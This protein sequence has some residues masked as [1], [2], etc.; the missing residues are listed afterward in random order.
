MQDEEQQGQR[1]RAGL[2]QSLGPGLVTGAADDDPSGI[3]TYTQAGAQFGTG[4]LWTTVLTLPLMASIQLVSAR[5][6]WVTGRGLAANLRER[7]P[8]PLVAA[9]VML[10]V[11]ANTINLGADLSAM[12]SAAHLLAG[13]STHLWLIGFALVSLGLQV[14]LPLSRYSPVL[15]GLTLS[16]L[17]Y[18]A[19]LFAGGI[20][21]GRVFADSLVPHLSAGRDY[22]M[23]IVA[24]LGTTI[25]PYL[26]F[27]QASQEAEGHALRGEA[28]PHD[29]GTR[30][31]RAHL[32]RIRIDTWAGMLFSNVIAFCIM[33][34]AALA[35]HSHGIMQVD[36][37][38]QAAQA[39]RPLVGEMAYLLFTAGLIGTGMLAVPVLAGSSAYAMAEALGWPAG[40]EKTTA[41]ARGFYA[42]LIASVVV[43]VALNLND[44]DPVQELLWAAVLNGI[45]AVPIMVVT[46]HMAASKALMGRF[47]I[48]RR[49]RLGGWLATALMG[50]ASVAFLVSLVH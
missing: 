33:L 29:M 1:P 41:Q 50:I 46:M 34:T 38:E 43:G 7:Y 27:W 4:M 30:D 37:T 6:G 44:V 12:A 17:A 5:I 40:L 20:D 16:L 23:M 35:L 25:S 21:W 26:F 8:A 10:L 32:R 11:V 15:K 47:A 31:A 13:G 14:F 48:G 2:I 36:T 24:V 45:A 9:V 28:G 39:L 42:V 3:A 19:V 18:A 49:L 22:W